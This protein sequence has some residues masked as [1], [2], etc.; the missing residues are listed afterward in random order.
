MTDAHSL[1]DDLQEEY[2]PFSL[3]VIEPVQELLGVFRAHKLPIIWSF[4]ARRA[5]DGFT[6]S[7]AMDN[8]YGPEG[9]ESEKNGLFIFGENGFDI[10]PEIGPQTKEEEA[11]V[12]PSRDLNMFWNFDDDGNSIL[13]AKLKELEIDTIV[14]TGAW[15]DECILSTALNAFSRGYDVIVPRDAVA[16]VTAQHVAALEIMDG[17]CCKIEW[18]RD[19]VDYINSGKWKESGEATKSEL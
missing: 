1:T 18:T 16:T 12:F 9:V 6:G 15:T 2:R 19:V 4:W 10:L 17:V 8:F 3:D 11:M 13:E 7:R 5:N 14:L